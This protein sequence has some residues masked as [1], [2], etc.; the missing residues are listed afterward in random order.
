[1]TN[2]CC[3][4]FYLTSIL[5]LCLVSV[6]ESASSLVLVS[7]ITNSLTSLESVVFPSKS[8]S[9]SDRDGSNLGRG[10]YQLT[11]SNLEDIS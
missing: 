11:N 2:N 1:M 6:V 7:V 5:D 10:Y 9:S 4:N 8:G 3:S